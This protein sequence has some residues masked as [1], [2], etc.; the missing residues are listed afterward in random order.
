MPWISAFLALFGAGTLLAAAAMPPARVG[1]GFHRVCANSAM[2]LAVLAA[3]TS[4]VLSADAA[5]FQARWYVVGYAAALLAYSIYLR[6]PSRRPLR[7]ANVLL[8]AAG[9][10]IVY[11]GIAKGRS[12]GLMASLPTSAS[13]IGGALAAM[14]L[15]HS[16]L[17]GGAQ[18]FEP[19]IDACRLLIGAIV[20]R[21]IV[22]AA[23][24]APEHETLSIW[25]SRDMV[26]AL[27][28]GV[29]YVV[30]IGAALALAWMSL[31]CARIHSNQSATGILYVVLGF[32]IMGELVA[33]Y[34]MGEKGLAI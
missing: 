33:A 23:F 15:G 31:A 22:S 12:W 6:I 29:R 4:G 26:L 19:L 27:L 3:L 10:A 28:V 18:S 32:A 8:A 1:A 21:G 16:Y 17:S 34:V 20:V 5:R 2:F 9:V 25:A 13:V 24:F 30:G 11:L 7:T 14:L